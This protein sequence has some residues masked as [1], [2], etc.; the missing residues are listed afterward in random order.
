MDATEG[1]IQE[2]YWQF[3]SNLPIKPQ[4]TLA[5]Y[6][7]H[8]PNGIWIP[9]DPKASA[10]IINSLRSKGWRNGVSDIVIAYP[11]GGYHGAYIELKRDAKSVI[12]PEQIE[13]CAL[14]RQVGYYADIVTGL[15]GAIQATQN[16]LA[17]KPPIWK[18]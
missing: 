11:A 4:G 12:S 17:G 8:V 18:P 9:G 10:R 7:Y 6:A 3:L 2:A 14:T 15:D 13:W 16:F 5:L 1:K